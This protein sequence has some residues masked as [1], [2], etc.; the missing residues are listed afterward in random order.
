MDTY[1][2]QHLSAQLVLRSYFKD[3]VSCSRTQNNNCERLKS[4][5]SLYHVEH[6]T[7]DPMDKASMIRGFGSYLDICECLD[8][9][10]H[11][12]S[13]TR[14]FKGRIYTEIA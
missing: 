8:K 14:E 11:V 2:I 12:H 9:H 1:N 7:T 10:A 3:K 6:S 13:H 4:G 5:T